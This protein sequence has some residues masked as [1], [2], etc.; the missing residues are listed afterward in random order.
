[1]RGFLIGVAV[2]FLVG[3]GVTARAADA[4]PCRGIDH[5]SGATTT[6][7]DDTLEGMARDARIGAIS[8]IDAINLIDGY[9]L[10][11]EN[12]WEQ[13]TTGTGVPEETTGAYASTLTTLDNHQQ[14]P[15][16]NEALGQDRSDGHLV[17]MEFHDAWAWDQASVT[18]VAQRVADRGMLDHWYFTGTKGVLTMLKN[19][20]LDTTVIYRPDDGEKVTDPARYGIDGYAVPTSWTLQQVLD[21]RAAGFK[22]WARQTGASEYP[23]RVAQQITTTQSDSPQGW[24]TY[25]QEH[26]T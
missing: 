22:V 9:A 21:A 20:G 19:T 18:E 5:R 25:C 1:M 11:H 4:S 10:Y 3:V 14:V 16:L 24:V 23:I 8:E 7:D 15:T 13:G 26:T 17:L 2:G 6:I 12:R